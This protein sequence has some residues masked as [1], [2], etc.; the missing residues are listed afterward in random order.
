MCQATVPPAPPAAAASGGRWTIPALG[1]I[2]TAV[3]GFLKESSL[4]ARQSKERLVGAGAGKS[5]LGA[6]ADDGRLTL[7]AVARHHSE[8]DAWIV[9]QGQVSAWKGEGSGRGGELSGLH[10]TRAKRRR[11]FF[12]APR[13]GAKTDRRSR[14]RLPPAEPGLAQHHS[15]NV[16]W[17]PHDPGMPWGECR[18]QGA[19]AHRQ[20]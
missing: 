9:V 18:V 16:G 7:E 4:E 10:Q 5:A 13:E 2:V 1:S 6:P 11:R 15:P 3:N 17:L 19:P 8:G 14:A 12:V 20:A